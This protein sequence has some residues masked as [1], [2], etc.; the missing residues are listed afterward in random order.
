MPA[1][2]GGS[3]EAPA[4]VLSRIRCAADC[5][6]L[7]LEECR[8]LASEIRDFLVEKV[9]LTGGHLGPN[10][11][12]VELTLALHR[13]YDSPT[14]QIVFDTGHQAYVHKILTGRTE[15]FNTLRQAGGLSGYP[16]R[17]ESPHDLVENSHASTGLSYALGLAQAKR[18]RAEP[19]KVVVVVGDGSLTGGMAYEALN[20]IGALRPDL[21]IVLNDNGRSYAPTV[22]G[23]ADHFARLRLDPRYEA[24][25]SG[26]GGFLSAIPA[27]GEP[28][29]EMARRLKTGMKQL[30]SPHVF[31]EDLGIKYSG[32]IDGHDLRSIEGALSLANRL[33]GP[34]VVHVV[35]D[36]GHG[37]HPAEADE[38]DKF[39]GPPPFD[40][41]TGKPT[42]QA[43]VTYTDV[44]EEVLLQLAETDPKLVAIT[45]A[46][47]SSTGLLKFAERYPDRFYD[48]GIAEQ[49]AVTFAAGLAMGGMHPI[50][51]IYSTFL[52]R[53]F[54]QIICDVGL[55]N[56]PVTF[57]LDRAGVT[58]PDGSSHHGMFDLS[59]LRMVPNMVVSTPRDGEELGRLVAT[60]TRH[61]GPFAI[62]YPRGAVS[63][64]VIDSR[65][66]ESLSWE[67]VQEGGSDVLLCA[68]GKMVAVAENAAGLL[69]ASGVSASVVN[70]RFIK[71][72]D[73]RLATWA[74]A[75]RAVVTVEDNTRR[76]GLGASVLEFLAERGVVRPVRQV[77]LPDQFLPHG[78]QGELL[79]EYGLTAE[80]VAEAAVLALESSR[81]SPPDQARAVG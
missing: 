66:L 21:T 71:P 72:T 4:S 43:R 5:R 65:P 67:V 61:Q 11:G 27:V 19:G 24:A 25:K 74:Q 31:F 55:H 26:I 46:M 1:P 54:D 63:E 22:G 77:A 17:S 64:R 58:G 60:A 53:A 6:E 78:L 73:R 16:N 40:I 48:V 14:D 3:G 33:P 80:G 75:H 35:T 57:V 13:I 34:V 20:N 70:A 81:E 36:K 29:H 9:S 50:V 42:G 52:Q 76:G 39:H 2:S 41:S 45:A 37:F 18:R 56:L 69:A 7:S 49:H 59:Y 32:P 23:L 10:L 79:A 28:A 44:F 38:V 47:A 62:R 30:V 12:V 68:S 8:E 51:C 15:Q